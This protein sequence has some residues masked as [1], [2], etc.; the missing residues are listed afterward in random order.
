ML[1]ETKRLYNIEDEEDVKR[2]RKIL[3]NSESI[4][5]TVENVSLLVMS[6]GQLVDRIDK[7]LHDAGRNI[8]NANYELNEL[9]KSYNKCAFSC[10]ICLSISIVILSLIL[11]IKIAF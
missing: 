7:N 11:A 5:R 8:K 9:Y 10:Q 6:Q 4:R 2:L 3:S 1:Q